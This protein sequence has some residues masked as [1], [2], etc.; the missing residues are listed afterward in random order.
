MRGCLPV[1]ESRER[2]RGASGLGWA[3]CRPAGRPVPPCAVLAVRAVTRAES[4]VTL[5]HVWPAL[6]AGPI[7][8]TDPTEGRA[9]PEH[10]C[11]KG[12]HKGGAGAKRGTSGGAEKSEKG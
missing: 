8:H 6:R 3:R 2:A 12:Q 11:E 5:L 4:A 1:R 9:R 7:P 10:S